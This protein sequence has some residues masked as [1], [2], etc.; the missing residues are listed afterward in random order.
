[1]SRDEYRLHNQPT[2]MPSNRSLLVMGL[3]R[4]ARANR[5]KR[6]VR[7]ALGWVIACAMC[8]AI[9]VAMFYGAAA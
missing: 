3:M 8:V 5:N 9:G 4:D 2:G 7:N 1:M 6:R